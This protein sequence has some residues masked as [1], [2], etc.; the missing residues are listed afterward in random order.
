[1]WAIQNQQERMSVGW[2]MKP[3]MLEDIVIMFRGNN[4]DVIKELID[5][6]ILNSMEAEQGLLAIYNHRWGCYWDKVQLKKAR[7]F[8]SVVLDENIS[9][10]L[11]KDIRQF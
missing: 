10:E 2:E 7:S 9:D 8:E 5:A 6:A 4:T 1:M 3:T 11:Q